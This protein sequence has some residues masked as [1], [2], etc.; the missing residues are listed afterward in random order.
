MKLSIIYALCATAILCSCTESPLVPETTLLDA[1]D[2]RITHPVAGLNITAIAVDAAEN[3]WCGTVNGAILKFD[4]YNCTTMRSEGNDAPSRAAIR[5][6][7]FDRRGL[8]WAATSGAGIVRFENDRWTYFA[9]EEIPQRPGD[10]TCIAFDRLGNL[11]TAADSVLLRHDGRSWSRSLL[12]A[13]ITDMV[14]DHSGIVWTL[15]RSGLYRLDRSSG[16]DLISDSRIP[17]VS[18]LDISSIAF[19]EQNRLWIGGAAGGLGYVHS[20]KWH[21]SSI[22]SKGPTAAPRI[23]DIASVRGKILLATSTGLYIDHRR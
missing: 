18:V 17:P 3:I 2:D 16:I 23:N 4:G 14:I 15:T 19:D 11:W 12:P 1:T 5:A 7:E 22:P 13:R 21:P 8:P 20:G 6:I 9:V 10:L